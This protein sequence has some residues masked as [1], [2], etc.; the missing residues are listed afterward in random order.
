MIK[1]FFFYLTTIFVFS[2]FQTQ[3][4]TIDYS[5]KD[6]LQKI[7]IPDSL[8]YTSLKE[9]K[10]KYHTNAAF[11]VKAKL[12][13]TFYL[14]RAIADSDSIAIARGYYLLST[15]SKDPLKLAYINQA[16]SYSKNSDDEFYP[17]VAYLEKGN[18][19][20]NTAYYKKALDNYFIAHDITKNVNP[21]LTN[22]I[23]FNIG[24]LK[25]R[26]GK[27]AEALNIFKE[28][29]KFYKKEADTSRFLVSL[30]AI[31]ESYTKLNKLDSA[32]TINRKGIKIAISQNNS[33]MRSY[34]E[35]NEGIN[36]FFKKEYTQSRDH[37]LKVLPILKK[38]NDHSNTILSRFYLGKSYLESNELQKAIQQFKIIDTLLKEHMDFAPETAETYKILIDYY[39]KIDDKENLLFYLDRLATVD[40]ILDSNYQYISNKI[41]EDF[42]FPQVLSEKEQ[43]INDLNSSNTNKTK[44]VI[45]L[46]VLSLV[47]SI[48]LLYRNHKIKKQYEKKFKNLI[49]KTSEEPTPKK[50]EQEVDSTIPNLSDDII[51]KI[52]QGLSLFISEEAYLQKNI[53]ISA[54]A[55]KMDS[56]GKY[57]SQ[58]INHYEKKKFTDYVNNLRIDYA[59]EKMKNDRKFRVYTIKAISETVGFSNP[60]SFSQAFFK[61][62][63][64]KPS[65]FIKKLEQ[66]SPPQETI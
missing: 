66:T 23:K 34:F 49:Q 6:N 50:E 3:N 10:K 62:T 1:H 25:T 51:S 33:D 28:C 29:H 21:Q 41:I 39:K 35:M 64:I 12:Y 43:I 15:V 4:D 7:E 31:S 8:K 27:N 57:L 16:I 18:L 42:D 17:A 19:F 45:L 53:S 59:I 9:L 30:F 11:P 14:K 61:K 2:S 60:V 40:S 20:L 46:I 37:L 65:Y 63:G 55:K 47:I 32:S 36:L 5:N 56:N 38:Q 48:L 13:A 22:D 52:E 58:Y 54:L 44:S 26:V 24:I